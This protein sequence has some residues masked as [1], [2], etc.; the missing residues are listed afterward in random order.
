[1]IQNLHSKDRP[2]N[3]IFRVRVLRRCELVFAFF[4]AN[5]L[6]LRLRTF[7]A[8][9]AITRFWDRILLRILAEILSIGLHVLKLGSWYRQI[10]GLVLAFKELKRNRL[11]F[12]DLPTITKSSTV[13]QY[14]FQHKQLVC[15]GRFQP[16]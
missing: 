4:V 12:P 16:G 7:V 8:Y 1:M 13:A 3:L 6:M 11:I 9:V 2:N 10:K 15:E 5:L 14:G